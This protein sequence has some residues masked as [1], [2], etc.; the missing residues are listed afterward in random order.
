VFE[1][2]TGDAIKVI[3]LA[4]EEARRLNHNFVGSEAILLGL[5]GD[6]KHIAAQRL[7]SN[8]VTLKDARIE[9]EKIIGRGKS[10][11]AVEIP[12]TP[13]AKNILELSW[14][15]ARKRQHNSISTE[16]LLMASLLADTSSIRIL[17]NLSVNI[18][19][20]K[21]DTSDY[22]DSIP[23]E[24]LDSYADSF[25]YVGSAKFF[26]LGLLAA[27]LLFGARFVFPV[28]PI[29]IPWTVAVLVFCAF[30]LYKIF[31]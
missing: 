7:I 27:L 3:M 25:A 29:L 15:E 11:P 6:Q 18:G 26:V 2:F 4:Q 13:A 1:R 8:G 17:E 9:S 20:L 19:K 22:L 12:F 31:F 23:A 30:A 28:I 16:H 5:L 24:I 21:E 10:S 14:D